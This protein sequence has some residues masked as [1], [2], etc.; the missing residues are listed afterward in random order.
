[1]KVKASEIAGCYLVA[2]RVSL[3]LDFQPVY[4]NKT[5]TNWDFIFP[6]AT[7]ARL[8][9][10]ISHFLI[11]IISCIFPNRIYFFSKLIHQ[12]INIDFA[13]HLI[14]SFLIACTIGRFGY[15]LWSWI[16]T[17]CKF[18][19]EASDPYLSTIQ[20]LANDR[21]LAFIETKS[22]RFYIAA[23]L[24]FTSDPNEPLKMIQIAPIMT[25]RRSISDQKLH[26][27]T[28]Y[29]TADSAKNSASRLTHLIP[30]SEVTSIG[31]YIASLLE[32][33]V[34]SRNIVFDL[35]LNPTV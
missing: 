17:I 8:C 21:K 27:T 24:A 14:L 23:V 32:S 6:V 18:K 12:V 34:K 35:S 29:Q 3:L 30:F 33:Q 4:S 16:K 28:S 9:C 5:K 19:K 15:G 31:E 7:L 20:Y 26:F 22:G 2:P 10:S 11:L 25:G 13:G 1:M